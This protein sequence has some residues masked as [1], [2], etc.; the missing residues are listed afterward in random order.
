MCLK[1]RSDKP[2]YGGMIHG[3]ALADRPEGPFKAQ[4][5]LLFSDQV[6]A[7]DP[8]VWVQDNHIYAA[9]KDWR[10]DISGTAGIARVRAALTKEGGIPESG[11]NWEIPAHSHMA[12]KLIRWSDGKTTKL[13]ALE[14]PFVLLGADGKPSHLFTAAS[15]KNPFAS[16]ENL[17]FNLC[18]PLTTKE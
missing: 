4:D 9:V 13:D 11:L 2:S 15:E 7:E 1:E 10:G 12:A 6:L 3:W 8:C 18:Q 17:P 16:K 14:R 5:S